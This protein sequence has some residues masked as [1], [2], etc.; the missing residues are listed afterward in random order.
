MF[1]SLRTIFRVS[2]IWIV[3]LCTGY[4]YTRI[5]NVNPILRLYQ[6]KLLTVL[7][8]QQ[9]NQTTNEIS[10]LSEQLNRIEQKID[11][12]AQNPVSLNGS[13]GL[14]S[15]TPV[16]VMLYVFNQL[17]DRKLPPA[18]QVNTSSLRPVERMVQ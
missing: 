11:T 15:S 5:W 12:L 16:K 1:R 18:Q 13:N 7:Q 2:V 9:K 14:V 10:G 4:I 3:V 6:P 8:E 17:E